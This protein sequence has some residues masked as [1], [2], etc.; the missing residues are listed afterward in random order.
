M[1]VPRGHAPG[2]S[3]LALQRKIGGFPAAKPR[4]D[5]ILASDALFPM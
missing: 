3:G 1:F 5:I 4:V 2:N